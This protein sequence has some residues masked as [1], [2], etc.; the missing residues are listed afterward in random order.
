MN[1]KHRISTPSVFCMIWMACTRWWVTFHQLHDSCRCRYNE[2]SHRVTFAQCSHETMTFLIIFAQSRVS[3]TAI[4]SSFW[5]HPLSIVN[6][7][8]KD[9]EIISFSATSHRISFGQLNF[10]MAVFSHRKKSNKNYHF[11][12]CQEKWAK[13]LW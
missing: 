9:L 3:I 4:W 11:C 5:H 1:I 7:V 8:D 10:R 6:T 13:K 2:Y 12:R